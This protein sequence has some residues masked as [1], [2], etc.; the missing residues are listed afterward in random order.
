MWP[1]D[2][3]GIIG[4]ACMKSHSLVFSHFD[5]E[6]LLTKFFLRI[7]FH[8]RNFRYIWEAKN[9]PWLTVLGT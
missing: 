8:V 2:H 7:K 6:A 9:Y 5:T 1:L 4:I 3:M